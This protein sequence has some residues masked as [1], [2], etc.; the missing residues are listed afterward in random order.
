MP[1]DS[2]GMPGP[3]DILVYQEYAP[4]TKVSSWKPGFFNSTLPKGITRYITNGADVSIPSENLGF[5]FSGI[6]AKDWGPVAAYNG[7]AGTRAESMMAVKLGNGQDDISWENITLPSAISGRANAELVWIPV[8]QQGVLAVVGGVVHPEGI[9]PT[10]LSASQKEDNTAFRTESVQGLW[11]R[12]RFMISRTENGT[13]PPSLPVMV[14]EE[15]LT[16][17]RHL[18]N[19]TGNIPRQGRTLFC[20]AVASASDGSSHNIYIYGGY[21]GQDAEH[22]PYDDVYILSLP[23]FTWV[24]GRVGTT[25]HGRSGHRC[26]RVFPDQMLIVGGR[27][28]DPSQCVKGGIV[29]SLNL[30]SLDF[31]TSYRPDS[32]QEY[33]VPAVLTHNIGGR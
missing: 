4:E 26:F 3:H 13:P 18:Q 19:T 30:N 29:Q 1:S 23:S 22:T 25:E 5:Y 16:L 15:T 6:H 33:R 17:Y 21:D 7:S 8:S 32:W 10:G 11:R 2:H 27:F 12:F 14:P 31:Q 24:K 20:S 28:K 9:Y